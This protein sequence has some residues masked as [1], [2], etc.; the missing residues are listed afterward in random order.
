[1]Q[2]QVCRHELHLRRR[3]TLLELERRTPAESLTESS[4]LAC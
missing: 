3:L 4:Q 2:Q 1:M